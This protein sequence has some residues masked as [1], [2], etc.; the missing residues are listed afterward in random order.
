MP[1]GQA[2]VVDEIILREIFGRG[3][4]VSS[5]RK[6]LSK[7]IGILGG[8]AFR[9]DDFAVVEVLPV[10]LTEVAHF[11]FIRV[12]DVVL[13]ILDCVGGASEFA[14]GFVGIHVLEEVAGEFAFGFI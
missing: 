4:R 1:R 10:I 11:R 14:V 12:G 6:L 8:A 2:F 3:S 5:G 9:D 13:E 7:S